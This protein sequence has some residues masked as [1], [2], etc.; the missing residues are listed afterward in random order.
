M[1]SEADSIV[2]SFQPQ[3]MIRGHFLMDG[4]P[5]RSEWYGDD[6]AIAKTLTLVGLPR[7]QAS[8]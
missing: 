5:M 2:T 1:L 4:A 6:G 8:R 3:M 7:N